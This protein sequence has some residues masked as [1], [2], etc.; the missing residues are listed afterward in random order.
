MSIATEKIKANSARHMLVKVTPAKYISEELSLTTGI[1]YAMPQIEPIE[2]IEA[3]GVALSKVSTTSPTT[4]QYYHD[5][6]A[7]I[8]YVGSNLIPDDS[9]YVIIAFFNLFLTGEKTRYLSEDPLNSGTTVREWQPLVQKYPTLTESIKDVTNGVFSIAGF[10]L[11]LI[12]TDLYLKGLLDVSATFNNADVKVWSAINDATELTYK[13]KVK[14]MSVSTTEIKLNVLD[15]F[16]PLGDTVT[17][18]DRQNELYAD[19]STYPNLDGRID[20]QAIPFFFG[21]TTYSRIE[22]HDTGSGF[23]YK[24]LAETNE[25]INIDNT[26]DTPTA[27]ENEIF[28]LGRVGPGGVAYQN[29]GTVTSI[30]HN[31]FFVSYIVYTTGHNMKIG[32]V[33]TASS[34]G[35][36][37]FYYSFVVEVSAN[38]FKCFTINNSGS[39]IS[40]SSAS[41][42]I[43]V[44][45]FN[46][47]TSGARWSV[48]ARIKKSD[49]T[50]S[51]PIGFGGAHIT[52]TTTSGGNKL[53]TMNIGL[54]GAPLYP[55][56]FIPNGDKILFT[57]TAADDANHAAIAE[58]ICDLSSLNVNSASFTLA[59]STLNK[60][61]L[62]QIPFYGETSLPS[63]LNVLEKL[64]GS[65]L[66]FLYID[67]NLEV[68]YKLLQLPSASDNIDST[69]T[70]DGSTTADVEYQDIITQFKGENKHYNRI[71]S[72]VES[73][74]PFFYLENNK[75]SH[76]NKTVKL[77][78]I[79]HIMRSAASR[80]Q[81]I[82]NLLSNRRVTNTITVATE[83]TDASLGDDI[84]LAG[85]ILL[86]GATSENIKIVSIKKSP[87][88][89]T[90]KAT[91]L[92]G[93]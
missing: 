49:G 87:D 15:S 62:F 53:V 31:L 73:D 46:S 68:N 16:S 92:K 34:P 71:A 84:T 70:I 67:E 37:S 54:A 56:D 40:P 7:G 11:S 76:L 86:G 27:G 69:L 30:T 24:G 2:K 59:G 36:G 10:S 72:A 33:F 17:M 20:K 79:D 9:S 63:Y 48:Q 66:G 21:E 28:I 78:E 51:K 35:G 23:Y 60:E 80:A 14:S 82:L 4:G 61:C 42:Q 6:T 57:L 32:D 22:S 90:V 58:N 85:K 47:S 12:D 44:A 38:S 45:S 93:L 65:T 83:L 74:S 26:T 39:Y 1:I 19:R 18:G 13:G 41:Q 89:I 77:K 55:S 52:Q 8:L 64:V 91:D 81:V 43:T 3:N 25:A 75:A 88:K 29:Y 50:F 5:E